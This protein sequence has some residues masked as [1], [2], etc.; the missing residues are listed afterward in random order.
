MTG[1]AARI[2]KEAYGPSQHQLGRAAENH[3]KIK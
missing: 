3:V 2:W 1:E